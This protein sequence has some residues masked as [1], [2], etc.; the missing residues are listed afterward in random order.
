MKKIATNSYEVADALRPPAESKVPAGR[1]LRMMDSYSEPRGLVEAIWRWLQK[2][3]RLP[4]ALPPQSRQQ[5]TDGEAARPIIFQ[6]EIERPHRDPASQQPHPGT[7]EQHTVPLDASVSR[8]VL[9]PELA[10]MVGESPGHLPTPSPPSL[11]EDTMGA[12][13]AYEDDVER[14]DAFEPPLSALAD[15]EMPADENLSEVPATAA[16]QQATERLPAAVSAFVV[17]AA[18]EALPSPPTEGLNACDFL[19]GE[20]ATHFIIAPPLALTAV[21]AR[22]PEI[23]ESS[24]LAT[25]PADASDITA[26]AGA[27]AAPSEAD[28]GDDP[29]AYLT[30]SPANDAP[31]PHLATPALVSEWPTVA[32][33]GP[34]PRPAAKYTPRLGRSPANIGPVRQSRPESSPEPSGLLLLDAELVITFN[35]GGWGITL[36][37]LLRRRTAMAEEITVRL[38][39]DQYDLSAIADDLFEPV[40]IAQP[41]VA[42]TQGLAAESLTNPPVRWVRSGRNLHVFTARAGVAGF[43]SAPRVVIGQENA[44]LCTEELAD[45]VIR[46][47]VA[48]GSTEPIEIFG[49]GVPADWRCLRGIQPKIPA[50]PEACEGLLLAL[51]PLPHADIELSGGVS[52]DRSAWLSGHPPSIRIIGIIAAPGEV[53]IDAQ[54]ASHSETGNW[55]AAGWDTDGWHT[56][57]YAGLSRTYEIR[58]APNSWKGWQAHVCNGLSLCGAL[59]TGHTGHPA[60]AS[61]T[62]PVWLVGRIPGEIVQATHPHASALAVATP[63]F[64]PVWAVPVHSGKGRLRQLPQLIGRAAQPHA[65]YAGMPKRAVRLWCQVLR[66]PTLRNPKLW[67]DSGQETAVLWM[68][69]RHVARALWRRLR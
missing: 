15:T 36:S 14:S 26:L 10:P 23:A 18:E 19:Q 57:L 42:L 30:L 9:T 28:Q 50:I 60:F 62:G 35:P 34:E 41:S 43:V 7:D 16:E 25:A 22:S 17:P 5:P 56:V 67:P 59:A 33:L 12:Q 66:E 29:P 53:V 21:A 11:P 8:D 61:G 2:I 32:P 52:L 49:P 6:R 44:V 13:R 40:A 4:R 68:Q 38:G 58:R 64:E 24:E 20:L 51:V 27:L 37:F 47:C 3:L 1:A 69:Y 55:V 39:P 45:A 63:D 48:T 65:L 54:P 31:S 46:I